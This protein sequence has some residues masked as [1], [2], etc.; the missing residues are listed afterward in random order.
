M[1]F[2]KRVS[3]AVF[4]VIFVGTLVATP[5]GGAGAA[6]AYRIDLPGGQ[7]AIVSAG[8]VAQIYTKDRTK[9]ETRVLPQGPSLQP[10]A[11]RGAVPDR[12]SV[13]REL[14]RSPQ[15]PFE[16]GRVLVVFRDG[17]AAVSDKTDVAPS[18]LV[19]IRRAVKSRTLS[20][21]QIPQYT[22]DS[23]A[24]RVLAEI[25]TDRVERLFRGIS[26]STLSAMRS[27]A[28][29][30][31]GRPI[32]NIASAYR[33]HVSGASVRDAVSRLARLP[34]V[35]YASADWHVTTMKS[36]AIPLSP[37]APARARAVDQTLRSGIHAPLSPGGLRPA[38]VP[39]NYAVSASAQSLLNAPSVDAV[40]AFDEIGSKFHQLPGQGEIITDLS[41]GDVDDASE[42]SNASDPCAGYVSAYGPTTVLLGGQRYIDW[43][44]MP[45]IPTY[46]ADSLGNLSGTGSVCGVDPYLGEVGLDFSVM[47]PLP[48]GLQ[49]AGETGTGLTDLLGIAPGASYRL[50]VPASS[51]P[52]NS[53]IYAG[54][55]GA[56]LQ[57]PRPSAITISLG[58]GEDA[59]GFPS[60][61]FE[62]DPL[63]ESLIAAV[64]QSYNVIVAVSA[65]D[66]VRTYTTVAIGPDG[67]SAPTGVAA[68]GNPITNI[69]DV[70]FSTT[71]SEDYD[72]GS[73]D[74]GGTTLDDVFAHPPQYT[75]GPLQAQH[76]YAE[77]RWTGFTNFSSG[78][79]PRVNVSAPSDNILSFEHAQGGA[80]DG[81]T[82]VLEGGTSASAPE[83]A[84]AAAVVQ[85]VGRLTGH[86]F[87]STQ[88]RSFLASTATAVP[89]IP[90]AGLALN[91]G[92]QIDVR[93][94]V[95]TLL[96]NAGS[97]GTP[98]VA[99][100][101]VE[102]RRNAGNLNGAFESDTDPNDILLQDPTDQDRN[103]ISWIT[104]APDWEWLPTT[105]QY[106]LFVTGHPTKVIA[107]TPWARALPKT[108]LGAAGLPLGSTSNR[109]VDLTYEALQGPKALATAKFAL[110]FG[111]GT[112]T[113]YGLLAPEVPPVVTGPAIPVSYDLRDIAGQKNP[114]LV[115]SEPGRMSPSTGQLFHPIYTL[116]LTASSHG[117]VNVPVSAL[118]GGGMYGVDVIYDS[119]LMRHSDP[120]FT[121]VVPA[122]ANSDR[123]EAPLLSSNGSTPGHYLEVPFGGT[124]QVSYNVGNVKGAT[125]A[126]LEISAAG[127]GAWGI[128][129]P[130]NNPGGSV[131]DNNGVDSGSVYCA[132]VAGTSGT[133]TL[134]AK[135][136]GLVPTL[137]HVV[138]VI[139]LKYGVA[140]GEAG[141][142]SDVT[143]D[144]VRAA[145]GGGV[146]NGFGV[147]QSGWD[148][149]VT[150][151]QQT[152][153]GAVLTSLDTF[154]QT[155]NQIV[156]V[157][158][159]G[160]GS[161]YFSE[162]A[163][164]IF[165]G[166]IGLI[167]LQSTTTGASTYN[168]L[169]TVA[170]GTLGAAWTPP[171]AV[172]N[173]V[174]EVAE[175]PTGD[176][177]PMYYYDPAGKTNDN[178]RLFTSDIV[179]DTFSP[180]YDV[181]QPIEKEGLP[182]YWGL[183]EDSRLKEAVLLGEDFFGNCVSP[184]IVTVALDTGS[185]GSFLGKGK[186]YPY[187]IAIDSSTNRMAVP[188]LCDGDLTI[189]NLASKSGTSIPLDGNPSPSG[190]VFNGFYTESDA[191]NGEFLVEQTTAPDFGANNNSLS[192]VLVYGEGGNLLE[193]K[194]QF[195]LFG[196]FLSIQ[197]HNL[198]ANP[199]RHT[200]YLIGPG[201]A[202]LEP[203]SY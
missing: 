43:P 178:Y 45:L 6:E 168:L 181:S 91:V 36:G 94:A 193:K 80:A 172:D 202:Q 142:V 102:Q 160:T 149:F 120:A 79:G 162:G 32:L 146:Q 103:E 39:A 52:S 85:Q 17:T 67:G 95:E 179:H 166:D 111:P 183:G 139:P 109:T 74:A 203:F 20:F 144:G 133:V 176:V 88:V 186:G 196:A 18:A 86:P 57:S 122:N 83:I 182:N 123:A 40:A 78:D 194:E 138:R 159:S 66:G 2:V 151:G 19:A 72:S 50:V 161:L 116:A 28:Q 59:Y 187:G 31:L 44:S 13:V 65:N 140:A 114:E 113:H 175:N 137:N 185:V 124:F 118:Q 37:D 22:N 170:S 190:N 4:S 23:A 115:V 48:N 8:G 60:R 199:S 131:C 63:A 127:P 136:V 132:P 29:S 87:S 164:G 64:V 101:A 26:P 192:R 173:F 70:A 77:T 10:D 9:V 71:P 152:A 27:N 112:A 104:I 25:G 42:A 201:V 41:L 30:K 99:R 35:A 24:N 49:R 12:Q 135:T 98:S 134:D 21:A 90:Q 33:L 58:F 155:S 158:G 53:D 180:I 184:T 84:A 73:I 54:L 47:A 145:D 68:P 97:K 157:D 92:P 56:A 169:D 165:G 3:S 106:R 191:K 126:L 154:D 141:L 117:T 38:A 107:V 62:D 15:Q 96:T 128:Y 51:S 163:S 11:T 76:A 174:S 150:S 108:I 188:T 69:D 5:F 75:A 195:D 171:A 125:G 93:R 198:Q 130:F 89:P 156:N 121:R 16:A 61:Y 82:V 177:V 34:S 197:A 46:T 14:L 81:V 147:S 153:S 143:M 148:G 7:T 55:L 100:V 119:T 189:Y 1:S 167:G 200:G 110:T 129:N 105:V